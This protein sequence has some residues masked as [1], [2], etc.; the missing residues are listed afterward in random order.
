V[1]CAEIACELAE[2]RSSEEAASMEADDILA[3][4]PELPEDHHH[5]AHLASRTVREAVRLHWRTGAGSASS[6]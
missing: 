5:C 3:V 4:V 2:G 1:V 6:P